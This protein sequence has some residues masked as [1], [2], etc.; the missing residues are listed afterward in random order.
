MRISSSEWS[1][2]IGVA[3]YAAPRLLLVFCLLTVIAH[4][5]VN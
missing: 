4:S 1:L 5:S 3:L 2:T